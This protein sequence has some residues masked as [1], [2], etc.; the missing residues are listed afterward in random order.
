MNMRAS[1]RDKHPGIVD[2]PDLW[3]DNLDISTLP[4]QTRTYVPLIRF[5]RFAASLSSFTHVN[6]RVPLKLHCHIRKKKKR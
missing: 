6:Y 2:L 1:N 5:S 3:D 4:M